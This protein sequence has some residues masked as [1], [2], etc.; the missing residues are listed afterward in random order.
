MPSL[1]LNK[2]FINEETLAQVFSCECCQN[3]Q[4]TTGRRLLQLVFRKGCLYSTALLQ[5]DHFMIDKWDIWSTSY[6]P[7]GGTWVICH[8][9]LFAKLNAYSF[10]LSVLKNTQ[11]YLQNRKQRTRIWP[12]DCIWEDITF[13]VTQ[14]SIIGSFMLNIFISD[15]FLWIC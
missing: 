15:F 3:L 1:F 5:P 12:S 4:H 10:F 13:G 11:E 2:A 7:I 6:W 8:D 14:Y 9:I